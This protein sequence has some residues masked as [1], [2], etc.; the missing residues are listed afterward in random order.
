M[1]SSYAQCTLPRQQQQWQYGPMGHLPPGVYPVPYRAPQPQ[2][3]FRPPSREPPIPMQP[4]ASTVEEEPSVDTPLM[5]NK[6][7]STV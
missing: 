6:R 7:E 3:R 1:M 4:L 2:Q 5:A